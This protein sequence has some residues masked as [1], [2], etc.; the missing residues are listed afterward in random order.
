MNRWPQPRRMMNDVDTVTFIGIGI[1][2]VVNGERS[3]P[4]SRIVS[5]LA[6]GFFCVSLAGTLFGT[7]EQ[8]SPSLCC[9]SGPSA[10]FDPIR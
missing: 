8:P 3:A 10:R 9:D 7:L 5:W 4:C 1:R 2:P 6:N